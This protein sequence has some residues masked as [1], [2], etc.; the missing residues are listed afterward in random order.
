MSM[1]IYARI[2]SNA[3]LE[4]EKTYKNENWSKVEAGELDE[5]VY[6]H[7]YPKTTHRSIDCH[8]D[9]IRNFRGLKKFFVEMLHIGTVDD[10]VF[11]LNEAAIKTTLTN[12]ENF[13]IPALNAFNYEGKCR[14]VATT[15]YRALEECDFSNETVEFFF[16]TEK[17]FEFWA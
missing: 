12:A 16:C 5:D 13:G 17:E 14:D 9:G 4:T 7:N 10:C 1:D 8:E 15:C 2:R 11:Y 3:E 6:F